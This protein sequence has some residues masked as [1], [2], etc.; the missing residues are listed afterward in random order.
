VVTRRQAE[1]QAIDPASGFKVP[2]R[3]LVRQWDGEYVDRRFVDKRN[4]QDLLKGRTDNP[5]LD[6]PR[7][8]QADVFLAS[9]ITLED[10]QTPI[11]LEN[12]QAL[13][14]EGHVNGEGL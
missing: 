8:E 5:K 13:L 14:S 1:P 6:H 7:P 10:G 4:P 9:N 12:G 2:Y 3:N 11:M